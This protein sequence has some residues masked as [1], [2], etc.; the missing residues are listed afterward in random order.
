MSDTSTLI[1]YQ[2]RTISRDELAWLNL[3]IYARQGLVRPRACWI[4][5]LANVNAADRGGR[6]VQLRTI[7]HCPV[8][9][10]LW[11][12]KT[13]LGSEAAEGQSRT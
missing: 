13:G 7:T 6:S 5:N 8:P 10:G 3:E 12:A 9:L 1:G 2:T 11:G 4:P